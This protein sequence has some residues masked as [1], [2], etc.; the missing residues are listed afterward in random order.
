MTGDLFHSLRCD[1]GEQMEA[2]L[3]G[4]EEHGCGVFLYMRQE[5]RGIGLVNKLKAYRLQDEG[6]DTVEANHR[7]GFAA[8]LRE[9]GIGAQILNDLGVRKMILMTNNPRKIVGLDS[10]GLQVVDRMPLE[11]RPN[12]RNLR[13]LRTKKT[14]LGHM[15]EHL[16]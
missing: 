4:I 3:R 7:L 14:K 5:G 10:Y 8:D 12:V 11:I 16:D 15:L 9:Y 2:A 1:C 6:C 13:Y